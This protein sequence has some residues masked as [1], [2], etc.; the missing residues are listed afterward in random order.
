[1]IKIEFQFDTKHGKYRD[2]L[3]LPEDHIYTDADIEAMKAERVNN[4]IDA[5]ENPPQE[6]Q[7]EEIN[8]G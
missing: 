1:M 8:N 5:V 6:E 4:W 2:A 7:A 3:Y